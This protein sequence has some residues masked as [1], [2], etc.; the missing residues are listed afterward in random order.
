MTN[1]DLEKQ[2]KELNNKISELALIV[3]LKT[4]EMDEVEKKYTERLETL[5]NYFSKIRTELRLPTQEN[6]EI[7]D[8]DFIAKLQTMDLNVDNNDYVLI[9][10]K[11]ITI[12]P[13]D[14]KLR[15]DKDNGDLNKIEQHQNKPK[16]FEKENGKN[17]KKK[18]SCSY[19]NQKGHKR[20]QCPKILYN[21]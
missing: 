2:I 12:T 14:K 5:N 19:C 17:R 18:I 16:A 3:S 8:V 10:T 11:H 13:A 6:G 1:V 15:N 7:D 20:A 4:K 9:P 21:Q